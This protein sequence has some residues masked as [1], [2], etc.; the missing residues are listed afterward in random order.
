MRFL[1]PT[2]LSIRK[3]RS[4][5]IERR[6]IIFERDILFPRTGGSTVGAVSGVQR[7]N[8]MLIRQNVTAIT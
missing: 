8:N 5:I 7:H 2:T 6:I 4:A 3:N 1:I